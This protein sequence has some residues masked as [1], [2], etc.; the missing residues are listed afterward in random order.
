MST[1][2]S[3]PMTLP[4]ELW[5]PIFEHLSPRSLR[6]VVLTSK[7]FHSVAIRL[8]Y[9]HLILTSPASFVAA[10]SALLSIQPS[11]HALLLSISPFV[12]NVEQLQEAVAVVSFDGLKPITVNSNNNRHLTRSLFSE[13]K[14]A[15]QPSLVADTAR[16]PRYDSP[17]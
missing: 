9:K 8:L 13:I 11:P 3:S 5:L 2:A 10:R 1:A 4:N 7:K 12:R 16:L 17:R 14:D 6:N 15:Y